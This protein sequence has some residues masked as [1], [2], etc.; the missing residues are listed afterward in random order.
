LTDATSVKDLTSGNKTRGDVPYTIV[1]DTHTIK[2][3][4][5]VRAAT[6]VRFRDIVEITLKEG[7]EEGLP[8]ELTDLPT[9]YNC[10]K[11]RLLRSTIRLF[12]QL[13]AERRNTTVDM[14]LFLLHRGLAIPRVPLLIDRLLAA[15]RA[16]LGV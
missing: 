7:L 9:P 3:L 6:G 12:R 16:W 2:H 13:G 15:R 14:M 5:V 10:R 11:I 4:D 8:D 1:L